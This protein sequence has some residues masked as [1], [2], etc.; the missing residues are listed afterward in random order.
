MW[1]SCLLIPVFQFTPDMKI[2]SLV[3]TA[4]VGLESA[5]DDWEIAAWFA[6]PNAWLQGDRPLDLVGIDE[7]AIVDAARVDRFRLTRLKL[8]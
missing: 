4:I 5:F 1:R 2:R 6:Q 7:T 8:R 3:S